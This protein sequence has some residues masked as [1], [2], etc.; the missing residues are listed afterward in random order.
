VALAAAALACDRSPE[1]DHLDE[2]RQLCSQLQREDA[3]AAQAEALLGPAT[4]TLCGTDFPPAS[5]ADT[6]PRDG[7]PLCLRVWAW[8]ARGEFL[9]GGTACSYGCELR[10]PEAAPEATCSVRFFDGYEKPGVPL[11]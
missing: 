8:R 2:I 11:P 3:G 9:C 4:V 10:S 5:S 6:C 7:T 1:S